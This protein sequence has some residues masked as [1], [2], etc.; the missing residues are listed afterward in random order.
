MKQFNLDEYLANPSKKVVTR[1][2]RSV[3]IHCTNYTGAQHIIAQV[4]GNEYS[5]AFSNDGRFIVSDESNCDLFFA[6]EKHEGWVNIYSGSIKYGGQIYDTEK[7]AKNSASLD[8]IA[9][10]KIEWEE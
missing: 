2:G 6:P 3:K 10:V 8:V 1:D 4:E 5:S 7:D 9:T